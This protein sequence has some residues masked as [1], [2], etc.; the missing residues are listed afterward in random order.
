MTAVA[1]SQL[2]G[3]GSPDAS[4]A[5]V[6]GGAHGS[7]ALARSLGRRGIPVFLATSGHPIARYSHYVTQ[8]FAWPA[9]DDG[10]AVESLIALARRRHLEGCVLI[11]AGDIELKILSQRHSDLAS[12]FRVAFA[13]WE[14]VRWAHDKRLTYQRAAELGIDHPRCWDLRDP[15]GIEALDLRF[16]VILKPTVHERRNALT[17]AKAWRADDRASLGARYRDAVALVGEDGVVAQEMIPGGGSAQLSYAAVWHRGTPVASLVA[18]R[19]RQYPIDFGYTSTFVETIEQPE[20]ER[21]AC[22]FLA[23]LDFTGLVEVEFKHDARDDRIKLLD[24][25]AR[26]WTWNGLGPLAGVDFAHVLWRVARGES[27]APQRG[28]PHV[29]WMHGSRDLIAA[30]CEIGQGRSSLSDYLRSWR[31]PVVFAAFAADDPLP[32]LID[33]PLD[34][35]R[36]VKRALYDVP[37]STSGDEGVAPNANPPR[38]RG[39]WLR[40]SL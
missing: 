15:R 12:I 28:R 27:V 19:T 11:P 1:R 13:P 29:G 16:P 40:H 4:G 14:T 36:V 17:R 21:A 35:A 22:R 32:G 3:A 20:V 9:P 38:Q 30:A 39:S 24:V 25:N 33:V 18:R 31:M 2:A 5:L 26:S 6:V 34:A 23:A 8:S 37:A 7:L 10:D